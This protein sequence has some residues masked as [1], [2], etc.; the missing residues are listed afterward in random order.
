MTVCPEMLFLLFCPRFHFEA[1]INISNFKNII[2]L[3]YCVQLSDIK[4]RFFLSMYGS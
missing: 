4:S 2:K 1:L 3:S